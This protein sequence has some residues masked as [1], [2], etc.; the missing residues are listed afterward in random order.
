MLVHRFWNQGKRKQSTSMKQKYAEPN[1]RL[2][3]WADLSR[4]RTSVQ[5]LAAAGLIEVA[6]GQVRMCYFIDSNGKPQLVLGLVRSIYA[7]VTSI[8]RSGRHSTKPRFFQS[9]HD[10]DA[11]AYFLCYPYYQ[12]VVGTNKCIL[13]EGEIHEYFPVLL[14]GEPDEVVVAPASDVHGEQVAASR[15][16]AKP[17]VACLRHQVAVDMQAGA[18]VLHLCEAD[19]ARLQKLA[20]SVQLDVPRCLARKRG[21]QQQHVADGGAADS[22][23]NDSD[24]ELLN[25]LPRRPCVG[26]AG[27]RSDSSS[28]SSSSSSGNGSDISSEGAS[29]STDDSDDE[30]PLRASLHAAAR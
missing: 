20:D 5:D 28:S 12:W 6:V 10:H 21:Q 2:D 27:G 26:D 16:A 4:K 11:T 23:Y 15:R 19:I 14:E 1:L 9:T 30:L 3:H 17:D 8:S 22:E 29:S 13:C 18:R 25:A 7:S 24:D